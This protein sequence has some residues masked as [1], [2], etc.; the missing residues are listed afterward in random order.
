MDASRVWNCF[1]LCL[2]HLLVDVES[3][4]LA[5]VHLQ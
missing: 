4:Y 3:A 1:L 2:M 5:L